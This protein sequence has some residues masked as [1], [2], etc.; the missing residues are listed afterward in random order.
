MSIILRKTTAADLDFVCAAE[1]HPDNCNYVYQWSPVEHLAALSDPNLAHYVIEDAHTHELLGYI[2][3]DEVQNSSHSINLRRL[4]VT[5]KNRGVGRSALEAIKQIAFEELAAHRLCLDVF[6][7]NLRAYQLY[8]KVGF[9][10]E[11]LLRESYLR[12]GVYASQY[13]MAILSTEYF[14]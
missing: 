10:Q 6:S 11:G 14:N 4:V 5:V 3:L 1:S 8:Q 12:N 2:I 9:I 7:D 13:L